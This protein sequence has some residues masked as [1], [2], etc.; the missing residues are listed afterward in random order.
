MVKAVHRAFLPS[1]VLLL[2]PDGETDERL[3]RLAP[4]TKGLS[5]EE[6]APAV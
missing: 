5:G 1:K 6:D 4:E 2:K 3:A